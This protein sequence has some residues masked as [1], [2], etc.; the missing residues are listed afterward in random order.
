MSTVHL[1]SAKVI[2]KIQSKKVIKH[3][4]TMKPLNKSPRATTPFS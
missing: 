4:K 2:K 3:V 1:L